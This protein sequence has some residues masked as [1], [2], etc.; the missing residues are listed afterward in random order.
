V[1][2]AVASPSFLTVSSSRLA[3]IPCFSSLFPSKFYL[4][5]PSY[6]SQL[7]VFFFLALDLLFFPRNL[8]QIL[9]E[10][11]FVALKVST[12]GATLLDKKMER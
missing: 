6:A 7:C 12:L 2:V 4:V 1:L 10:T 9:Q 8:V 3:R 5:F 11:T